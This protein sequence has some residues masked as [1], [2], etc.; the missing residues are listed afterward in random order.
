MKKRKLRKLENELD[1]GGNGKLD[2]NIKTFHQI[3]S[4]EID[5]S[6]LT[7]KGQREFEKF[8]GEPARRL[9]RQAK[10]N[11]SKAKEAGSKWAEKYEEL[12]AR[13][14]TELSEEE[15]ETLTKA[16]RKLRNWNE[17]EE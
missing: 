12:H 3:A 15:K 8:A 14:F 6:D 16:G 13:D 1:E 10:E 4:G 17:E 9:E 7:E 2:F 11:L 5:T